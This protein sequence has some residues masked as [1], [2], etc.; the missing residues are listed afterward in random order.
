MFGLGEQ[1]LENIKNA[2]NPTWQ[3]ALEGPSLQA[4]L[5]GGCYSCSARCTQTCTGTCIGLCRD[6]CKGGTSQRKRR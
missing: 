3:P 4:S 6:K 2:L 1:I 5:G